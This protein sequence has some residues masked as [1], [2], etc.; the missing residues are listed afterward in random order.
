MYQESMLRT[1]RT[2]HTLTHKQHI[3]I[4]IPIYP[5]SYD[6]VLFGIKTPFIFC[7]YNLVWNMSFW[8]T[9]IKKT[10]RLLFSRRSKFDLDILFFFFNWPFVLREFTRTHHAH[11]ARVFMPNTKSKSET[12][13]ENKSKTKTEQNTQAKNQNNQQQQQKK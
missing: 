11:K 1:S 12:E 7:P 5:Q 10:I 4:Y 9:V 2:Q 13:N 6:Q 8:L 3:Y